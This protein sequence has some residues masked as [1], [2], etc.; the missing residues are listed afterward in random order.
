MKSDG[1]W[2]GRHYSLSATPPRTASERS[3]QRYPT[4]VNAYGPAPYNLTCALRQGV[5]A[6]LPNTLKQTQGGCQVGETKKYGPNERKEQN[7][8]K[9]TKQMGIVNLSDAEFKILVIQM[10][11]EIIENAKP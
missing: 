1:E 3:D 2:S 8:P 9:I 5:K 10:L 11:R 6:A 4:L 7:P